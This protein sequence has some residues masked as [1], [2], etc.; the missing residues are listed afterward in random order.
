MGIINIVISVNP[1]TGQ[2]TGILYPGGNNPVTV[3]FAGVPG[4]TYAVER[5]TNLTTWMPIWTTNAPTGSSFNFTDSFGDL[6]GIAPSSAYYRL[7]WTP[8]SPAP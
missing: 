1:L 8:P 6:G 5:S 4:Y 3:S 7:S 2:A